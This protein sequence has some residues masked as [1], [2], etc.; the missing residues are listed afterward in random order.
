M[1]SKTS[2][3][4]KYKAVVNVPKILA[5]G[6]VL[7][8]TWALTARGQTFP[9][10]LAQK[11]NARLDSVY[12][13]R[14]YK[15]GLSATI[16][17]SDGA[18]WTGATGVSHINE[19]TPITPD[20]KFR[21]YSSTKPVTAALILKLA[22]D[23]LLRLEDSLSTHLPGIDTVPNLRG[24]VTIAQLLAHET[25]FNDYTNNLPFQFAIISN[26]DTVWTPENIVRHC[27]APWFAPGQNRR[28][29]S[30]NYIL[31]GMVAQ[32]LLNQPAAEA[33]RQTFFEPLGLNEMYLS[34]GTE[35]PGALAD[36][37]DN[38]SNFGLTPD[39]IAHLPFS[40][41]GVIT[42]AWTTG[43]VVSTARNLALWGR[44]LWGGNAL[45]PQAR[46]WM[47]NSLPPYGSVH[48]FDS[49]KIVDDGFPG[50]GVFHEWKTMPGF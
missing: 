10:E 49:S 19:R 1:R 28:Y 34:D 32:K 26:F 17:L 22:A 47:L 5:I 31:L 36:P 6:L 2:F 3:N 33:F 7:S 11:L 39:S 40:F 12:A 16:Y 9:P 37:H 21:V 18:L 48:P 13:A 23:G 41:R 25:G 20:H 45:P 15:A 29:S 27:D 4:K 35:V 24:D 8:G 46:D 38:L 30:T 14:P 44:K 43:G 42:G 50:Y